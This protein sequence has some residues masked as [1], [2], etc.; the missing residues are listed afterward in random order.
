MYVN[1]FPVKCRCLQ[2]QM[3]TYVSQNLGTSLETH[4]QSHTPSNFLTWGSLSGKLLL[5]SG[6]SEVRCKMWVTTEPEAGSRSVWA[7]THY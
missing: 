1:N 4:K 2:F 7:L 3:L 6:F 5:Q